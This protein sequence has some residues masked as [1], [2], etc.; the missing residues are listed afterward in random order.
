MDVDDI[1]ARM[2]HDSVGG[3]TVEVDTEDAKEE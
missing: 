3:H 2:I 1:I